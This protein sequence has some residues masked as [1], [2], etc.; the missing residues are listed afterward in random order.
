L[1]ILDCGRLELYLKLSNL[2]IIANLNTLKLILILIPSF[3][4][5]FFVYFLHYR[6]SKVKA[7][8]GQILWERGICSS[9]QA[10]VSKIK[11]PLKKH[12]G[13]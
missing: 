6:L 11:L 5:T 1:V 4:D 3:L 9:N 7:A 12:P 13:K 10:S 8:A 2:S